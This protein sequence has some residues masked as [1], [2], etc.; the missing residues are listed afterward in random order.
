MADSHFPPPKL[1]HAPVEAGSANHNDCRSR[2]LPIT[3][4]D[5][6][7]ESKDRLTQ[8]SDYMLPL[9]VESAS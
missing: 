2:Q 6:S 5:R 7:K 3:F 8:G 9:Y 4:D 1:R